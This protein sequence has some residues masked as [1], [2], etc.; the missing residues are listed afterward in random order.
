[1]VALEVDL[2]ALSRGDRDELAVRTRLDPERPGLN[3]NA[4]RNFDDRN[5][6][7]RAPQVHHR[8]IV[9]SSVAGEE[10]GPAVA[11]VSQGEELR[12][13]PAAE[14]RVRGLERNDGRR[15]G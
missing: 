10:I 9:G 6:R 3:R 1:G 12:I 2:R 14:L 11:A 7:E 13:R 4:G 8:Y 5:A 15:R